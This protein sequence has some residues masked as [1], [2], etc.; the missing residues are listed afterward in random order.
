VVVADA[1][2]R[3]GDV[4]RRPE[5]VGERTPDAVVAVDGD[6]VVDT[7]DRGLLD[8]VVNRALESE[9]GR[10]NADDGQSQ[11][12][13]LGVPG[14]DIGQRAQPVDAGVGPKVDQHDAAAQA[15]RCQWIRIEPGRR[16]IERRERPFVG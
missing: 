8:D 12:A 15:L 6:R 10:V 14:A 4:D 16:P 11:P 9:L 5:V 1:A 2:L 7:E 13:V 3:V